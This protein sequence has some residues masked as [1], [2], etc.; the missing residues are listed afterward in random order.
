MKQHSGPSPK[1]TNGPWRCFERTPGPERH[2]VR[3]CAPLVGAKHS[4]IKRWTSPRV[5]TK[6]ALW[7]RTLAAAWSSSGTTCAGRYFPPTR[8]TPLRHW[9]WLGGEKALKLKAWGQV[10]VQARPKHCLSHG[11]WVHA[12]RTQDKPLSTRAGFRDR[13]SRCNGERGERATASNPLACKASPKSRT[14]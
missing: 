3:F 2:C 10:P 6:S 9:H 12:R 11:Q 1:P 14:S 7:S 4:P 5:H 8:R 13:G